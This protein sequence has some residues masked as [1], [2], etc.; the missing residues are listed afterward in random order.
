M[1]EYRLSDIISLLKVNNTCSFPPSIWSISSIFVAEWYFSIHHFR[2]RVQRIP[3]LSLLFLFC[4][5]GLCIIHFLG[6]MGEEMK[7]QRAFLSCLLHL[8]SIMLHFSFLLFIFFYFT[9]FVS[10]HILRNHQNTNL[11]FGLWRS[12]L[13][14][15][16]LNKPPLVYQLWSNVG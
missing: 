16:C 11:K 10:E 5:K 6:C 8:I 13:R 9:T 7:C 15:V 1:E 14:V 2:F 3:T 12:G 4:C